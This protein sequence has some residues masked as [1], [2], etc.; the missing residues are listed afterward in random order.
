[1]PPLAMRQRLA[2]VLCVNQLVEAEWGG[3][4]IL[5][6]SIIVSRAFPMGSQL[7]KSESPYTNRLLGRTQTTSPTSIFLG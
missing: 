2:L 7:S 4:V 1:M 6:R 5:Y 3:G